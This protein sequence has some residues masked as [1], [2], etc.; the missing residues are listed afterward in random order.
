MLDALMQ[1]EWVVYSKH[2]LNRTDSIIGY[3]ARYT[4]PIAISNQ[5]IIDIKNDKVLFNYND[6][7]DDQSKTMSLDY[8]EFIR[9]FLIHVLPKGFMRIRH[10]GFLANRC[11]AQ[12]LK[13]IRK[14]LTTLAPQKEADSSP[15]Q[16]TYPC[17]K[18]EKG[19]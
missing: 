8:S 2:C 13:V 7:R 18:A 14:I 6:Y 15:E 1:K 19:S 16:A 17:P 12:S 10:Y 11:R 9:R 3:L 4:H 5:R